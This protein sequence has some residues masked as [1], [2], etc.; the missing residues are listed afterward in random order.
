MSIYATSVP[1]IICNNVNLALVDQYL[2]ISLCL[3]HVL[4]PDQASKSKDGGHGL[5]WV[6]VALISI[7]ASIL[8]IFGLAAAYKFWQ[9]KKRQKEQARFLKLF[10]D[11]DDIE[12]EL[13]IGPLGGSV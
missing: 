2:V 4:D 3:Y 7:L 12:D 5:H 6:I 1:T 8:V 11:T 13:G 9:K 10:E